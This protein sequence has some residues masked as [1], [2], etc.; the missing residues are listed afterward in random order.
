MTDLQKFEILKRTVLDRYLN[1][2]KT[3]LWSVLGFIFRHVSQLYNAW[4][5][6]EVCMHCAAQ[7]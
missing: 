2:S 1:T 3:H 5:Y 6:G 4:I 7:T